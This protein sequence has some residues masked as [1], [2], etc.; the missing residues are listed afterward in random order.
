MN[1]PEYELLSPADRQR[2]RLKFSGRR[3]DP[4]FRWNAT[5]I[6]LQD[7]NHQGKRSWIE[8]GDTCNGMTDLSVGINVAVLNKSTILKTI[9]MIRNYK[10]LH[11]GRHEFG[12]PV[13]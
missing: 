13:K 4:E 11:P 2:V 12:D 7:G 10:K 1:G 3:M 8:I 6:A 9:T 5:F